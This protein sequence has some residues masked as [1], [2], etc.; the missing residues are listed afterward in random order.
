M[1]AINH[2]PW[3]VSKLCIKDF[4]LPSEKFKFGI[5]SP[6]MDR[7]TNSTAKLTELGQDINKMH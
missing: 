5:L 7:L 6:D 1:S 3:S 4:F 2:A